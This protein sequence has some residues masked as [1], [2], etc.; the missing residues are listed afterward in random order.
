MATGF[1]EHHFTSQDGLRL[2]YRSYGDPL[3]PRTPIL[4]L[5]GMTRNA[6]DFDDLASRLAD[7]RWLLCPDYRGRGRSQYDPDWRNYVGTT[8]INDIRHLLVAAG[9]HRVVVVGTSMG[10]LLATA[11]GA[12]MPTALAGIVM[13]DVGPDIGSDGTKRIL[14]YVS[15][16]RPQ[17]D[18]ASAVAHLKKVLPTLSFRTE[19]AWRRFAEATFRLG[20]DGQLH[21]DWDINIA[22]PMMEPVEPERD[23]WQFF[24]AIRHLPLLVIRGGVSDVLSSDTLA[25]MDSEHAAMTSITIPEVGHAPS[26]DEP[27][28][29]KAI[30]DFLAAL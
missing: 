20:A 18:W 7:Q 8:Y 3:A 25:R 21:F 9:A 4:C 1:Q 17:A 14:E 28:S 12:I 13:N 27:Q 19:S 16:D 29:V 15:K 10:G 30:D 5:G 22:R 11:M 26:L 6:A 2:Y 24:R 23:L